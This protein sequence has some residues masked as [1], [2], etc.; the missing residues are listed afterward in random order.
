VGWDG[1]SASPKV[2]KLLARMR[3]DGM[4]ERVWEHVQ[5]ECRRITDGSDI[6]DRRKSKD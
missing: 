1:E 4:V 2:W 6:E 5:S 3:E